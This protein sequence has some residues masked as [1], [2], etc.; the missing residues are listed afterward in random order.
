M[1]KFIH[2]A[3]IHLD[4]PLLGL[5][6]YEGAPV[7]EIR[8]ATRRALENL[9]QLAIDEAVDFV[10]IAGD[11]YD[12]DW[13][14]A[15]T[16]L[17]FVKQMA[18][19]REVKIPVY[20]IAGNHDAQ[21]KMTRELRF[22]ENVSVF[23]SRKPGTFFIQPLNVAIHGQSYA[24]ADVRDNLAEDYPKPVPDAFNI[25]LLHT[26]GTG[27]SGHEPY[28]PCTLA[29]LTGKGYQ[30]W[31]L[32]H[33]H[34]RQALSEDPPVVF[35]GNVQGRHI[36]ETG[37]RGCMLVS[38]DDRHRTT[39]QFRALDVLRWNLCEIDATGAADCEEVIDR[40][41]RRLPELMSENAGLP[42]GI[43]VRVSGATAAHRK[44]TAGR[45]A[46]LEK[47]QSVGVD[48]GNGSVWIEKLLI[49]TKP[50]GITT[51][52]EGPIAELK[53]YLDELRYRDKD[54]DALL[55]ELAGLREFLPADLR[56]GCEP[57]DR[58]GLLNEVEALL[59]ERLL[60]AEGA[61]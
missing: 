37:P 43:R 57:V 45:V 53:E 27:A 4:S 49:D 6:R 8:G 47:M 39:R 20:L 59:M 35:P 54:V 23:S 5:E 14:D 19:L 34:T 42:L 28:A 36:R 11:L 51:I 55:E 32:G 30:Y 41:A 31:A 7:E 18:R 17:Y 26:C 58:L 44:L 46:V 38:V 61:R 13:R 48:L 2:A 40:F 29:L 25:G 60:G 16:G 3:D 21:N 24:T 22:P 9:V 10:L 12:G 52:P 56:E 33:V 1:F 15:G 50:E